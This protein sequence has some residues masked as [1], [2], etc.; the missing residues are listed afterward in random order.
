M[1]ALIASAAW[2]MPWYV[3]WLLPLAALGRSRMLRVVAVA[4]TLF[5]VLTLGPD[6][7]YQLTLHNVNLLN[8]PAGKASSV[9]EHKLE[10]GP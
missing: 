6:T 8:T 7:T 1:L 3:L 5:L 10:S 4:L 9:I 2:L